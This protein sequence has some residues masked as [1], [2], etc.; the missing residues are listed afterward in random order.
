MTRKDKAREVADRLRKLS[1]APPGSLLKAMAVDT[2][3]IEIE[4]DDANFP[5]LHNLLARAWGLPVIRAN[6]AR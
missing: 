6:H 4:A 2:A 1:K 5:Y 3:L